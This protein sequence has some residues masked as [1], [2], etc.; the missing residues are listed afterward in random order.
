VLVAAAG[1]IA[2][3]SQAEPVA[4]RESF[5][6]FPLAL[7]TWVGRPDPPF[8]PHVLDVLGVDDYMS[9]T[10]TSLDRQAAN[11]YVGFYQKQRE[12]DTIHSPLN[13]LP[14]AGWEPIEKTRVTLRNPSGQPVEVNQLL[15]EKGIDH[16]LV[17]YWYQS[18]GRTVA[19]EYW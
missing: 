9:R 2:R 11:L 5:S 18:H 3:A 17:I 4:V 13:C 10:Y 6:T 15:I 7:G 19:S 12:G 14:G 8:T 1:V 16:Q